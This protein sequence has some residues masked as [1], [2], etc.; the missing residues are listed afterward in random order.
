ML[1]ENISKINKGQVFKNYKELCSFLEEPLK[2]NHSKK[3]QLKEWARYFEFHKEG[4]K[5]IIDKKYQSPQ[6]KIDGR[7]SSSADNGRKNTNDVQSYIDKALINDILRQERKINKGKQTTPIF[8]YSSE[9]L[10]SN[11]LLHFSYMSEDSEVR[12]INSKD[13]NYQKFI[14]ET[15]HTTQIKNPIYKWAELVNVVESSYISRISQA[16]ERG[17]NKLRNQELIEYEDVLEFQFMDKEKN[18]IATK[19]DIINYQFAKREAEQEFDENFLKMKDFNFACRR[20]YHAYLLKVLKKQIPEN[21]RHKTY[22][23]SL[24]VNSNYNEL[25]GVFK[26]HHVYEVSSSLQEQEITREDKY[27]FTNQIFE[28]IKNSKEFS[29]AY[30]YAKQHINVYALRQKDNFIEPREDNDLVLAVWKLKEFY[31]IADTKEGYCEKGG[32]FCSQL[33]FAP[34]F[35]ILFDNIFKDLTINIISDIICI[36]GKTNVSS[37]SSHILYILRNTFQDESFEE[38]NYI[39]LQRYFIKLL[40]K[41]DRKKTKYLEERE[42]KKQSKENENGNEERTSVYGQNVSN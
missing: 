13:E 10:L 8:I 34:V 27:K 28:R 11:S 12:G 37:W 5:I 23:Q 38:D 16:I 7:S 26:K 14:Q 19:T 31:G 41:L 4:Q 32:W 25:T 29:R 21:Q 24:L 6:N 22:P 2:T 42:K 1:S 35:D 17:L 39:S 18:R 40:I 3:A 30:L 33:N 15:T 20:K 36:S 9:F